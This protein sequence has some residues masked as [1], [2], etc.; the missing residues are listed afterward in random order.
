MSLSL[1]KSTLIQKSNNSQKAYKNIMSKL[2]MLR[3]GINKAE[4]SLELA[5]L[6]LNKYSYLD[7]DNIEKKAKYLENQSQINDRQ[8]EEDT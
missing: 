4:S 2:K 3:I 6:I 8:I 5:K 1:E 7:P